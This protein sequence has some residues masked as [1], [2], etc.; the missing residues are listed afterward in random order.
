MRGISRTGLRYAGRDGVA[1]IADGDEPR[2]QS[3]ACTWHCIL[4]GLVALSKI[5]LPPGRMGQRRCRLA[6]RR[7]GTRG[8]DHQRPAGGL[9]TAR[10]AGTGGLKAPDVSDEGLDVSP[11]EI[12]DNSP[13]S[14]G[15]AGAPELRVLAEARGAD[16]R[17]A[18][19]QDH[20]RRGTDRHSAGC[21]LEEHDKPRQIE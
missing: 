16:T 11:D 1:T 18:A 14:A 4:E 2:A 13:L 3:Y 17:R 7:Q 8:K 21:I 9:R 10:R 20:A 15:G 12:R 5:A 19:H 6:G